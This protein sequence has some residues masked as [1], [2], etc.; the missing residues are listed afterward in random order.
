M[1][2]TPAENNRLA[3]IFFSS[4]WNTGE[5]HEELI[6]PD[7][8]DYSTVGGKEGGRG[9]ESF[10]QVVNMF[11]SGMPDIHLNIEDEIYAGDKV[12]HRWKMTGTDTEGLMGMPPSGKHLTFT[13]MTIVRMED[14]K[15]VER[16]TNVDELGI[17]QQLGVV[18]PPPGAG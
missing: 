2:N 12:V 16:W 9:P 18:P 7:A 8:I 3:H 5:F 14:G 15:I 17:L 6:S 11:R 1:A 13:G 4:A 10:R